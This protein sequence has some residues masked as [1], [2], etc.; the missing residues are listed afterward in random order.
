M[1][2]GVNKHREVRDG[3]FGPHGSNAGLGDGYIRPPVGFPEDTGDVLDAVQELNDEGEPM[4]GGSYWRRTATNADNAAFVVNMNNGLD[5]LLGSWNP[6]GTREDTQRHLN[7][8]IEE[9]RRDGGR[10]PSWPEIENSYNAMEDASPVP[11]LVDLN[12]PM[13]LG[14][15]RD[16]DWPSLS[17][18]RNQ[19]SPDLSEFDLSGTAPIRRTRTPGTTATTVPAVRVVRRMVAMGPI[20]RNTTFP[21]TAPIRRT[22]TRV[23]QPQQSRWCG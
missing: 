20:C 23:Q 7:N 4:K 15:G 19:S 2:V 1:R 14:M 22:R 11:L 12:W 9:T 10:L 6:L 16:R 3:T 17:E 5:N 13:V 18:F 21:G 8:Y